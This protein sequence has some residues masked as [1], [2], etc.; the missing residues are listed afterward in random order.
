[1]LCMNGRCR[2]QHFGRPAEGFFPEL[3]RESCRSIPRPVR[4]GPP[5]V[6]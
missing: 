5:L 3:G 2:E 1:M 6:P 4:A